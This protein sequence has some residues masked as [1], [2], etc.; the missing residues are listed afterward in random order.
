MSLRHAYVCLRVYVC[1]WGGTKVQVISLL[2]DQLFLVKFLRA[3][4]TDSPKKND[5]QFPDKIV[6]KKRFV[7]HCCHPILL[8]VADNKLLTFNSTCRDSGRIVLQFLIYPIYRGIILRFTL[9]LQ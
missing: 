3:T 6:V 9:F 4:K 5:E 2:T 8:E 1:V 7:S